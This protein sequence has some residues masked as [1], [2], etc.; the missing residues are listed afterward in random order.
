[1]QLYTLKHKQMKTKFILFITVSIIISVNTSA[2]I[3]RVN[4]NAGVA[5]DFTTFN[6]A[7]ISASVLAGDTI[8]IEPSATSY[9]GTGTLAK[10]LV[11]IGVGYFL[12]PTNATTPANTGLQVATQDCKLDFFRIGSGAN[13]SKFLGVT[14]QG[15]IYFNGAS[16]ISFE[17]VYFPSGPYFE[18]G[19]NDGVSFR[20]CFFNNSAAI[21]SAAIAVITN[22][23]CE[24]SV[25]YNG[26]YIT[27]TQLS[28]SGNIIRN[29]SIVGGNAFTLTN[30]YVANNIF[31]IG[32][33]STFTNCVI[34]NNLFQIA[35]TLPG[36]A[37]GNQLS[38]NMTNVYVGGTTGSL[39][40]RSALKAGSPAIAAGLTVGAV[41]TPDCGAY[42]A[43][44]PYKLSGIP[45]I[46]SIYAL[47]VPTA[48]PSGSTSMNITFSTRN[49]N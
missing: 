13:N 29:N 34:K 38:V 14:I 22:F 17:K 49:N 45:N 3:W 16:N 6:A 39:D 46:P 1:M 18:N 23:I 20:K 28:G 32:S 12:D 24:N 48:I 21:S 40:S 4:N 44:D 25:F 9:G 26:S 2:K 19:T 36:T 43:T 5:A 11:I 27:T 42:G 41:V 33:Q 31:A 47:T 30:C 8:H 37:T 10:R 15:S 35:Q 7:V